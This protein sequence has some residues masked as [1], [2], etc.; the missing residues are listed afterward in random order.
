MLLQDFIPALDVQEYV[1]LYRIVHLNFAQGETVPAKAYP[2]RPEHCLAFYPFD[3]ETVTYQQS[4]KQ[5]AHLRTVLYG[6]FTEVTH[7]S[8]GHRFLVVQ[9]IFF[10]GALYRLAG[11]A[12]SEIHN[13]YFDAE[14]V[15]SG[16]LRLVNEQ[17]FQAKSYS[18]MIDIVNVFVRQLMNGRRKQPL[19]IDDACRWML[20]QNG[21]ASLQQLAHLSFTSY[22]QLERQFAQRVGVSPK[23]Y[24][25]IIRFD[26]AFRLKNSK[27]HF[28]WLRIAM[29]C[30]YYD[31]QHLAKAYK[32][33][34]SLSP[35]TFHEIENQAPE[36]KF[37][38]SEGYY[39]SPHP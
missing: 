17:L 27:P 26:K 16:S 29:E 13:A 12:A 22:R 15:F 19:P 1:Q 14:T 32:D 10:P 6:Q 4:G 35:G 31:Y 9:I 7:R 38:L 34:T 30:G 2:P 25:R 21:H 37:G 23:T 28:D 5:V 33:F 8:I 3:T 20:Q 39:Q 11:I 18:A 24:E 36:R